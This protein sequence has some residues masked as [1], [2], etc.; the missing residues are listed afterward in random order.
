MKASR[1]VRH[2][3]WARGQDTHSSISRVSFRQLCYESFRFHNVELHQE[4]ET[5]SLPVRP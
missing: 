4:G 5:C 2:K 1:I 3:M